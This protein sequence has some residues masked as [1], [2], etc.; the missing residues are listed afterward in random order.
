MDTL[1]DNLEHYSSLIGQGK[2]SLGIT[3]WVMISLLV[4]IILKYILSVNIEKRSNKKQVISELRKTQLLGITSVEYLFDCILAFVMISLFR[5]DQIVWNFI[6]A[7]GI[8]FI[9]GLVAELYIVNK[10]GT[11]KK[12]IKDDSD[13]SKSNETANVT[14][15]TITNAELGEDNNMGRDRLGDVASKFKKNV[16]KVVVTT[17]QEEC[18][19]T[20]QCATEQAVQELAAG[21]VSTIEVVQD[22]A[23]QLAELKSIVAAIHSEVA[24]DRAMQCRARILRFNID[25]ILAKRSG[26]KLPKDLFEQALIDIDIYDKYCGAHPEF[27]NKI[28]GA[29]EVHILAEYQKGINDG[30][31]TY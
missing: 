26:E 5:S 12:D 7:P 23:T 30:F 25:L 17:G 11:K 8:G 3:L 29:A 21:L 4:A 16:S 2:F 14:N 24:E 19:N 18:K 20:Q 28:T 15:I 22:I 10:F 6:V 1:F 9:C 31:L 27:K 13:D